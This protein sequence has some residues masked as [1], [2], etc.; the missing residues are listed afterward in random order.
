MTVRLLILETTSFD[1]MQER[2][3]AILDGQHPDSTC[4]FFDE[5]EGL[6]RTITAK[7]MEIIRL[8]LHDEGPMTA[9][10]IAMR[11]KRGRTMA[12][13]D[14]EA[15]LES[16]IIDLDRDARY[17]FEFDG[18]RIRLQFPH[19]EHRVAQS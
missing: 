6:L 12:G 19:A 3:D 1:A 9:E 15:L 4:I 13:H 11:L 17:L 8:L 5:L 7:R 16:E 14:L 10:A 18:I 2:M